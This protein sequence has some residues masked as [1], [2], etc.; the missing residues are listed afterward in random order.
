MKHIPNLLTLGNLLCG[1]LGIL[2][3]MQNIPVPAA[4]FVWAGCVFDFFDGLAARALK[5]S[6]PIGKEL[7][8]L[9]DMVSFGVLPALA[10]YQ[11]MLQ[12]GLPSAYSYVAL[13]IALGSA[14]RLAKFNIDENQRESFIGLPT[15][16]NAL[17]VTGLTFLPHPV[18]TLVHQPWVLV[19]ITLLFSYLLISPLPLFALKFKNLTFSANKLR[20]TFVG[21]AVLLMLTG[22]LAAISACILAYLILSLVGREK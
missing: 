1:C 10:M 20:F 15:P 7:D 22:G 4:Y 14:W 8:S 5:V 17:F 13:V 19:V 3:I 21:I 16:A 9:A 18:F 6:S 12:A 11:M 2:S